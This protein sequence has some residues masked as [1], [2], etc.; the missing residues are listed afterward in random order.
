MI[1]DPSAWL[2]IRSFAQAIVEHPA[3]LKIAEQAAAA[4]NRKAET[5][6]TQL[7]WHLAVAYASGYLQGWN[8]ARRVSGDNPPPPSPGGD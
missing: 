8:T 3:H 6:F 4:I 1:T 2:R 7:R 5:A